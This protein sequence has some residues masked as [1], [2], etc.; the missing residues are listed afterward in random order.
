M[1]AELMS[2]PNVAPVPSVLLESVPQSATAA[3]RLFLY[4]RRT[5][6]RLLGEVTDGTQNT[7]Q[8]VV[9]VM[10]EAVPAGSLLITCRGARIATWVAAIRRIDT[11]ADVAVVTDIATWEAGCRWTVI[12][13]AVVDALEADLLAQPWAGVAV[14][15]AAAIDDSGRP[16]LRLVPDPVEAPADRERSVRRSWRSVTLVDDE[17]GTLEERAFGYLQRNPARGGSTWTTFLDQLAQARTA[18]ALAKV[19]ATLALVHER[20]RAGEQ[21]VVVTGSAAVAALVRGAIG[22]AAVSLTADD[23]AE[24]RRQALDAFARDPAIRVL[25]ATAKALDTTPAPPAADH[26]IFNDLA[27]APAEHQRIERTLGRRCLNGVLGVT[28]VTAPDTLDRFV[29]ASMQQRVAQTSDTSHDSND[30]ASLVRAVVEAADWE[31]Q[32]AKWPA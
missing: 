25:V 13:A 15:D 1:V 12:D 29:A 28:F 11:D 16:A 8:R 7:V 6:P 19:P 26:V 21:I 3:P 5:D 20:L 30:G 9:E 18:T 31:R 10:R 14:D 32:C 2:E 4:G 27:W 17:A 22:A 24:Q 23:T